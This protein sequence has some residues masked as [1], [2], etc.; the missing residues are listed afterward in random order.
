VEHG[1]ENDL[2]FGMR[3]SGGSFG[4]ITEFLYKVYP[5][6]ETLSC[7][8]FIFIE[9]EYDFQ[10]LD[11]AAKDGRY[12]IAV[13]QPMIYRKPKSSQ[14]VSFGYRVVGSKSASWTTQ[15]YHNFSKS[16]G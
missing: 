8:L 2:Y 7:L 3:A 6:P 1:Y 4:I 15:G 10:M 5:Q 9:N 11:R 13:F 12:A 14:L 16:T